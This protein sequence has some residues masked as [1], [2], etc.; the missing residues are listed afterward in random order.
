MHHD[1]ARALYLM[2]AGP[3][4]GY[5]RELLTSEVPSGEETAC[6]SCSITCTAAAWFRSNQGGNASLIHC[7]DQSLIS[8][9]LHLEPCSF[10]LMLQ[11]ESKKE[12]HRCAKR[13]W[14]DS[15]LE[16]GQGLVQLGN[17]HQLLCHLQFK[18][19]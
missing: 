18:T 14:R 3:F 15:Y 16:V 12:A 1:T 9:F 8:V 11:R 13:L 4:Q 2:K 7:R 5:C 10:M 19:D 17:V 6:D